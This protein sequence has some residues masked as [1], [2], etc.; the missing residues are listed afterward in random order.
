MIEVVDE[1]NDQIKEPSIII[2][3][4]GT[5]GTLAGLID[6]VFKQGWKTR[7]MGIPVLK[8]GEFLL[9]DIKNLSESHSKVNWQLFC[10]YHAGGYAK[11]N[12]QTLNFAKEFT[13]KNKIKLDK[14]YTAK[15][16]YAAYDLIK[17]GEIAEG[18]HVVIL[19]TG[20]LQGGVA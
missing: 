18:S 6:G 9:K 1:L 19:H 12:E 17:K 8:G 13:H 7:V 15:A 3:A 2:S 20:G 16:F 14:V 10:D 4:C 11:M 5:G